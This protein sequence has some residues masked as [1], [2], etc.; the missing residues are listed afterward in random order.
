LLAIALPSVANGATDNEILLARPLAPTDRGVFSTYV[1]PDGPPMAPASGGEPSSARVSQMLSGYLKA[2]FPGDSAS[3]SAAKAIFNSSTAKAKIPSASLR[4]ALA[5]LKGTFAEPGIGYILHAQTPA[6]HPKITTVKWVPP[7]QT[8]DPT[9]AVAG[10]YPA[11]TGDFDQREI[12]FNNRYQ[13]ENPFL[14]TAWMAHEP[15]HE[16]LSVANYE[17]AVNTSLNDLILIHQLAF[18][19][20]LA[21]LGTE[22]ARRNSGFTTER[23]NSGLGSRLGLFADN[24]HRQLF[25]GSSAD[26][27][28]SW[29][30][31]WDDGSTTATP[32]NALLGKYLANIHT[33]GAPACSHASFNLSLLHCLDKQGNS[34]LTSSELVKAAKA[35]KLDTNVERRRSLSISYSHSNFT[36]KLT[37]SQKPCTRSQSVA[38]YRQ[39]SGPDQKVGSDRTNSSGAYSV[40]KRNAS[41]HF[42]AKAA[43]STVAGTGVC[44]EAKSRGKRVS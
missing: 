1:Y 27:S 6:G 15:L 3:Q 16:D 38:V 35:M 13:S 43:R 10:V 5:A 22:L 20:G 14:F 42:Y 21:A 2:E 28:T 24:A 32:G 34:G 12:R 39:R 36:G 8:P 18:H 33:P 26:P 9:R 11:A 4:A 17:E 44:L 30:E 25:P 31:G 40:H 19:P 29:W 37:S 41:G 7:D 23:L